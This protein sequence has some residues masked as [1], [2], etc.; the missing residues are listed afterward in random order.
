MTGQRLGFLH[1]PLGGVAKA[2]LIADCIAARGLVVT[3]II[4]HEIQR[5]AFDVLWIQ[6]NLNWYPAARHSLAAMRSP[7]RPLVILWHTEPLPLPA[8]AGL[9]LPLPTLREVAKIVTRDTRA[10]DPRTNARRIGEMRRA[11]IPDVFV[12]STASR[13][14]W[15]EEHGIESHFVPVGYFPT[16][17]C[18]LGLERDIEAL[19]IGIMTDPRHRRAVRY[20]ERKGVDIT[21]I[22]DW[23]KRGLWGQKRTEMINRSRFFLGL[24]RHRG[25]LSGVRMILGMA[26]GAL[27][28]SEPI[29]QPEPYVPGR[30]FVS[31][32][33]TEMPEA[34]R[35]Y[36]EHRSEADTIAKEGQRFVTTELT[37]A[38]S[39]DRI[40]GIAGLL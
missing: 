5:G 32:P 39:V 4:D 26:N 37:I 22:G 20:L 13:K 7:E 24:Q 11:G 36:T 40:L 8:A 33:L 31:V 19:F 6:G 38:G 14:Y 29:F 12:V 23:T 35:Y 9:S 15:L 34:I 3:P 30:H 10:T 1:R 16:Q 2:G 25:E 28:I 27:V 18:D 17:G 21:A